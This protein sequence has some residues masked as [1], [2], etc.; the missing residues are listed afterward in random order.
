MFRVLRIRDFRLL[1]AGGLVSSLGSWLL[2]LAVPAH[3]WQVT[4]SLRDTGLTLAAEYLPGLVLG[5]V[6]GVI[7]D[8]WDR[9]RLMTGSCLLRAGA[10]AVML[11]GLAPGREWVLYTALIVENAGG[12]LYGPAAQARTPAIV[13][14]G[15]LLSSANSLSALAGGSMQLIGGPLGG[16]LL[17]LYGARWLIWADMA[18][19][20]VCAVANLMTSRS[21][22]PQPA[23]PASVGD[24]ARDLRAGGRVLVEEPTARALL[25]VTVLFLAGNASL[26]AVLIPF[27][28]ERLGGSGHTGILLSCLGVGVLASGPALHVLLDR[29]RVRSLLTASLAGN[30]AAYLLLFTSSS[31]ARALPAAVAIGLLGTMCRVVPQTAIQRIIPNAV[32]GRVSA[33]F[34]TGEAAATLAGAVAGPFL[35]QTA[36]IRGTAVAASLLTLSAAALAARLMPRKQENKEENWRKSGAG[37]EAAESTAVRLEDMEPDEFGPV[38]ALRSPE[39]A[40]PR[41]VTS[42]DA[43]IAVGALYQAHALPLIRLAYITLGDRA[44]AEDVVQD[45]FCG[46]FKRWDHLAEN[47]KALAYVRASVLNGCR[48][49][50]RHRAVLRRK[51]TH[52]VAAESAESEML[53]GEERYQLMRA[54]RRLPTRQREALVLR[55]YL[56]LPDGEIA[57]VMGVRPSTVRST[58]H[59]ALE[60]L[61]RI[62]KETV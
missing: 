17:M 54:V 37:S 45:A 23:R 55:F 47:G 32:L 12:V 6:A 43:E 58:M 26:S 28:I 13:G 53:S 22:D 48:S 39:P 42:D 4:G 20:L 19:Y 10:V 35:A 57:R 31:L 46:L 29:A 56:D 44:S 49:V 5:P 24:V 50:L 27:G 7:T 15:P 9:R 62:L 11:L 16:I 3:V 51:V 2:I 34:V 8:R 21:R 41:W 40:L 59:R 30:A 36:G 1:W 25:P 18:S 38:G 52:Q 14:T 60:T 61:G 33:A